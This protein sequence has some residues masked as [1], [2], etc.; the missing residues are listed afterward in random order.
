MFQFKFEV[1]WKHSSDYFHSGVMETLRKIR[2]SLMFVN[3]IDQSGLVM[4]EQQ[5][6][7]RPVICCSLPVRNVLGRRHSHPLPYFA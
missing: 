5:Q 7:T 4:W 3:G 2:T 1:G 6:Q